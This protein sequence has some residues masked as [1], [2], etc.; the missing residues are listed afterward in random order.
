ME[1]LRPKLVTLGAK[2][3]SPGAILRPLDAKLGTLEGK[4]ALPEAK[5]GALRDKSKALGFN[6]EAE[7]LGAY[8]RALSA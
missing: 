3:G 5:L 4:F 7:A 8:L 6:P 1:A 2:S